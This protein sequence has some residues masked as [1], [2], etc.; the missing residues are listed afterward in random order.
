MNCAGTAQAA[1]ASFNVFPVITSM[2]GAGTVQFRWSLDEISMN[3]Q[4]EN[5]AHYFQVQSEREQTLITE[6]DLL[7]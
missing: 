4:V 5:S 6:I 3:I 7:V 1:H 2:P